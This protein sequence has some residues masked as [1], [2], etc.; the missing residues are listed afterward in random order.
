MRQT[1]LEK[2]LRSIIR[3]SIGMHVG[4]CWLPIQANRNKVRASLQE[5]SIINQPGFYSKED[6]MEFIV[7]YLSD[8]VH[9]RLHVSL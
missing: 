7:S 8:T 6:P 9:L 4:Y 2:V 3:N 1:R 5:D